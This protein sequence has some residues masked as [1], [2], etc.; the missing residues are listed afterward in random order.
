MTKT[1]QG[2]LSEAAA[3]GITRT[4]YDKDKPTRWLVTCGCGFEEDHGW[5]ATMQPESMAS[6]LRGLGWKI[7]PK[8]A[9]ICQACQKKE[10]PVSKRPD[11]GPDP[12]IARRI[13]AALDD[14]FDE[15][16]KRFKT[17]WDD[18]KVAAELDVSPEI[19]IRIRR[20]AYGEIA[21]PA[22]FQQ[23]RD[24]LALLRME[25]EDLQRHYTTDV[26]EIT[27]KITALETR[28]TTPVRRAA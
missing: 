2:I 27:N 22:E 25:M 26:A 7:S 24:E 6:N 15:A 9:P 17:G 4:P 20:E 16:S 18:A 1:T 14:H 13:Y 12:K 11:L 21:E 19:V 5:K 28:I 10:R 3:F 23:W 8:H